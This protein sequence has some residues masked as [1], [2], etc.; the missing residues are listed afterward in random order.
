M[1]SLSDLWAAERPEMELKVACD[2]IE[3]VGFGK[4]YGC[5]DV[6]GNFGSRAVG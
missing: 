4:I 5:S 2:V 3:S 1:K 6:T